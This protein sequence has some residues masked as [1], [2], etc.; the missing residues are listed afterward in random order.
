MLMEFGR[1]PVKHRQPFIVYVLWHPRSKSAERVAKEIYRSLCN[2]PKEPHSRSIGIPV[3]FYSQCI[4]DARVPPSFTPAG[5][6]NGIVIL[7]EAELEADPHWKPYVRQISEAYPAGVARNR[8]L[9]VAL[10]RSAKQY[11][12]LRE[13]QF[14]QPL[15]KS[16]TEQ[17]HSL[18]RQLSHEFSLQ[19]L[20]R[21]RT[22][23]EFLK[24]LDSLPPIR[25]FLSHSKQDGKELALEFVEYISKNPNMRAFFDAY[26][27]PAGRAWR[28]ILRNTAGDRMNAVLAIQTD[29]YSSRE[30]CCIELL[31]AKRG[32]VPS[33]VV[34]AV[35]RTERRSFPYMGNLPVIR[36]PLAD[37]GDAHGQVLGTLLYE[38][39]RA[40]YFPL[41]V[42]AMAKAF[43]R[44]FKPCAMPYPPEL[45]TTLSM[46]KI[47]QEEPE[48]VFV[49][50]DP[51]IS[52]DESELMREAA[53]E[54][55]LVTPTLM[56]AVDI[57]P[58]DQGTRRS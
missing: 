34:N 13:Y 18:N 1:S 4:A 8:L 6:R 32:W 26:D 16:P 56:H 22:R 7:V 36:W 33:L 48:T 29:A 54:L 28:E 49:Y 43:H 25:V 12:P 14:L 45:L 41:R 46:R 51:P 31:L 52:A 24:D 20:E 5:E 23:D 19:L 27:I 57:A 21:P 2:D 9:P 17:Q 47:Q 53:P 35:T 37:R 44:G 55:T 40:A 50:P 30:W 42:T 3:R 10:S 58:R 15:G 11:P 39:L 38:V